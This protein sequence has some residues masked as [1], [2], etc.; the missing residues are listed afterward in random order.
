MRK[1]LKAAVTLSKRYITDRFLPDKELDIIDE[2]CS[3][4]RLDKGMVPDDILSSKN[5]IEGINI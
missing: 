4:I 2:A 3:K 1:L 5:K